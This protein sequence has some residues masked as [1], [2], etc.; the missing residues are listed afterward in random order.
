MQPNFERLKWESDQKA[1]QENDVAALRTRLAQAEE[2]EMQANRLCLNL[3]KDLEKAEADL[4]TARRDAGLL[5]A[6]LQLS[7]T[8][9]GCETAMVNHAVDK[10]L[11][12]RER[13]FHANAD[14][15]VKLDAARQGGA[16]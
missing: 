4:A 6:T 3:R 11:A 1:A 10:L 15:A 14:L 13:L 9:L 5:D 12:D 2:S 8:A 16:T 7:A